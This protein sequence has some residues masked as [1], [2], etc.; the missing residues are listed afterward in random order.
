ML[1]PLVLVENERTYGGKYDH[2]QDLTG[3]AYHFPNQYRRRVVPGREFVYYRGVRRK[4]GGRGTA[5]YF[6]TGMI[7]AVWQDAEQPRTT[8]KSGRRWYCEIRDYVPFPQPIPSKVDGQYFEGVNSALGW[9]TGIRVMRRDAYEQV[10]T[11]AGLKPVAGAETAEPIGDTASFLPAVVS[12]SEHDIET[13][14]LAP[15][16]PAKPAPAAGA[17]AVPSRRSRYSTVIGHRAEEI[18]LQHL[19]TTLP[20]A[21]VSGVRWVAQ[22]GETPGWDIEYR[23]PAGGLVAVEVKGTGA[24][25]F[26]AFEL[27]AGE[28]R[29]ALKL[30]DRYRVALVAACTSK[31]PR[32]GWLEDPA[33]RVEQGAL[34]CTPTVYR[35]ERAAK[36]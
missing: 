36:V 25:M 17:R 5:E 34:A 33:M 2:W 8:S 9:R 19:K 27:T 10:L 18:V 4:D 11:R 22:D 29:A 28:W 21:C 6:G 20:V 30:R 7:G 12:I 35:L 1:D 3:I 14:L 23:L 16:S 15:T 31:A 26:G 32:I 24:P 13:V